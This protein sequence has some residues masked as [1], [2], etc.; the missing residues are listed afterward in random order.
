MRAGMVY[1]EGPSQTHWI[2]SCFVL[3]MVSGLLRSEC[4]HSSTI[5]SLCWLLR[6]VFRACIDE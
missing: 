5:Y 2:I 6:D 3:F 4:V 1:T